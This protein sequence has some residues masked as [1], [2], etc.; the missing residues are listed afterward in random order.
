MP[1][2]EKLM[3]DVVFLY[4]P[5]PRFVSLVGRGANRTPFRVVKNEKEKSMKVLQAIV[6]RAGTDVEAVKSAVGQDALEALRLAEP[7]T[8]GNFIVYEQGPR[9]SFKEDTLEVVALKE[10]NSILGIR[11]ELS[12]SDPNLIVKAANL[13]KPVKKQQYIAAGEDVLVGE[14]ALKSSL[15][16]E[17]WSEVTALRDVISGILEQKAGSVPE[18]ITMIR[19]IVDNFLASLEVAAGVL[20]C[21]EFD[22]SAQREAEKA[23]SEPAETAPPEKESDHD[24]GVAKAEEE[25]KDDAG[26]PDVEV[27]KSAGPE[28]DIQAVHKAEKEMV[29]KAVAELFAPLAETVKTIQEEVEKLRKSPL[30]V[31]SSSEDDGVAAKN[32]EKSEQNIFAGCFGNFGR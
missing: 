32:I 17:M 26:Q 6:V 24:Q 9:E 31:V 1:D 19:K 11:G 15:S 20:K 12:D 30:S 10:D 7:K 8:S 14:E 27:G 29:E 13:F 4:D 21:E 3:R 25:K 16:G 28:I 18:K 22:F 2:T 23:A 5:K